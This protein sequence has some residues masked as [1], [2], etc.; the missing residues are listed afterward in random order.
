MN[1]TLT[2]PGSDLV[3]DP[4][5]DLITKK[6][7]AKINLSLDVTGRR[8]D[9]YHLLDMIMQ[10]VDLADDIVI[11]KV[12]GK[13]VSL[14]ISDRRGWTKQ[15]KIPTGESNLM[16]KA[17]KLMQA[18]YPQVGGLQMELIKRIPLEAGLGGASTDA[19]AVLTGI[20]ELFCLGLDE[21]RL[22][23]MG[24]LLGAD[25]P[26]FIRGGTQRVRGIGEKLKRLPFAGDIPG[27]PSYVLIIKPEIKALTKEVYVSYDKMDED[28]KAGCDY[29]NVDAQEEALYQSSS[30]HIDKFLAEMENLL[31]Y[32]LPKKDICLIGQIK[33]L[34]KD[35][36]AWAA[37]M[38]GSGTAVFGLF[39]DEESL[40]GAASQMRKEPVL[41]GFTDIIESRM[42]RY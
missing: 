5:F 17:A 21:D 40:K 29:P 9:G 38:S 28:L 2:D 18:L 12:P 7:C 36:G 19:A 32:A 6:A 31:L 30:G 3:A 24:L 11:K 33:A 27:M 25:V 37:G 4:R 16:V 13:D 42:C 22:E 10:T 23:Y 1:E 14:E 8:S 39:G 15:S 20:N 35:H 26:F 41:A 34:L